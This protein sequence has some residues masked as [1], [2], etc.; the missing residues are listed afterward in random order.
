M[1]ALA[2]AE[3]LPVQCRTANKRTRTCA[4]H[5]PESELR[6][7]TAHTSHI[8]TEQELQ[9]RMVNKRFKRPWA[10][11][12]YNW[13]PNWIPTLRLQLYLQRMAE[14][15]L[16]R[17]M[18]HYF[19]SATPSTG[20][21][22]NKGD[23]LL[24]SETA[25]FAAFSH[26]FSSKNREGNDV[27]ISF[28]PHRITGKGGNERIDENE[29]SHGKNIHGYGIS[30][31]V[32]YSGTANSNSNANPAQTIGQASETEYSSA[33]TTS[34]T[35]NANAI[36][37]SAGIQKLLAKEIA[38][39]IESARTAG[40][41]PSAQTTPEIEFP[42][43]IEFNP[44]PRLENS[45]SA[46]QTTNANNNAASAPQTKNPST[47]SVSSFDSSASSLSAQLLLAQY[48][49]VPLF[50]IALT[51]DNF[52]PDF[53]SIPNVSAQAQPAII[54]FASSQ[55]NATNVMA[56]LQQASVS[57][58]SSPESENIPAPSS[59][60]GISIQ[61]QDSNYVKG[62]MANNNPKAKGEMTYFFAKGRARVPP[63]MHDPTAPT[64]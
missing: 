18:E 41:A 46:S 1:P 39:G 43:I 51:P 16:T 21:T 57:Q 52:E 31:F 9:K 2:Q 53:S 11:K 20:N 14:S 62:R 45:N 64:E 54:N 13:W 5:K 7:L 44:S 56:N 27:S 34:T 61:L 15:F 38:A 49:S 25:M 17:A 42:T 47:I 24:E 4:E 3:R 6:E 22:R 58:T 37:L 12:C 59:P 30:V 33:T 60:Q 55:A 19:T 40:T 63:L 32:N 8:Q 35:A 50:T 36:E 29:H 28:V 26:T 10:R 48:S 23:R